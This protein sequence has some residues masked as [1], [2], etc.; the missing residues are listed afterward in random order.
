MYQN[1]IKDF[2]F[3]YAFRWDLESYVD[4]IGITQELTESDQKS[5]SKS[6]SDLVIEAFPSKYVM[7]TIF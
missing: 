1:G 7:I 4:D 6:P 2:L 3:Y 5:D